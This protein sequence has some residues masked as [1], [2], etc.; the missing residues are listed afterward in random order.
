MRECLVSHRVHMPTDL[1][2]RVRGTHPVVELASFVLT[3]FMRSMLA[4]SSVIFQELVHA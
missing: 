4:R 3:L 2:P 1:G